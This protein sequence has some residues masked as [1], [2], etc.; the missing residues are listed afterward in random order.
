M[1]PYDANAY[2]L[3]HNGTIALAEVESNGIRIDTAYLERTMKRTKR[4]IKRMKGRLNDYE[5]MREWKKYYRAKTNINSTQ[6][7]A[8]IL[9]EVMGFECANRTKTGKYSTDEKS[10]ATVDD[11]FVKD[12][13]AIKKLQKVNSTYLKGILRHVTSDGFM[14]PVFNLAHV[15]SFRSSSD[16]PNFQNIPIRDPEMGKLVR[17][18][19]IARDGHCLV[20]IDYSGAEVR[21]AACHHQDPAMLRY[22][23]DKTSDMHRDM[24]VECF[25]LPVKEITKGI[26]ACAKTF[27]FA[28]FYGDWYID[29]A[30]VLWNAI[31]TY[32]LKTVSGV[33]LK[34]HL[35]KKG[36]KTLGDL[37]PRETPK[38]GTFE[39]HIQ[40]VEK[41][42][43][44]TRFPIYDQWRKDH[45]KAYQDT[46]YMTSKMGFIFRGYMKRNEAINYP[47]QCDAFHLLLWSLTQ[48]IRIELKRAGLRAK[49]VG[50]IHDSLVADV[51]E[52]E[53]DD[54]LRICKRVMTVKIRKRFPWII[55][56]LEIDAEVT[57]VNGNWAQK[58][59]RAIPT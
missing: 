49:I 32:K 5:V 39:K 12:F 24:A 50:Q 37:N 9:Y 56:P 27:V 17:T 44:G 7:L 53:V 11:P 15:I 19:L 1:I 40:Q 6:Q 43:W 4:R 2:K 35:R 48:L 25:K 52:E 29:C 3:L 20:E 58:K 59:G 55:T 14:H 18:A 42:F 26:R 51:P 54:F 38:S 45:Y 16:S 34:K 41:E 22:I 33:P 57:P 23:N 8:K 28:Q 13:L 10:L 46:G 30:R 21:S 36:I 47:P 31:G